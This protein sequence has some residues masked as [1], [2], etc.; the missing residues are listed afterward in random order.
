MLHDVVHFR[1]KNEFRYIRHAS[2]H[3]MN[4]TFCSEQ[5]KDENKLVVL[6]LD[7]VEPKLVTVIKG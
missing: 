6:N 3:K 2:L 4:I 7:E 1:E 5:G